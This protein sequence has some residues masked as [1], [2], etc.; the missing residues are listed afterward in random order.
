MIWKNVI[1]AEIGPDL[2]RI[3]GYVEGDKNKRVFRCNAC[4]D[5]FTAS[6]TNVYYGRLRHCGCLNRKKKEFFKEL[7]EQRATQTI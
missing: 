6:V 7:I 5:H 4:G 2:T 3:I 1:G